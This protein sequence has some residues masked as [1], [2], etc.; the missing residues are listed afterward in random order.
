MADFVPLAEWLRDGREPRGS[1]PAASEEEREPPAQAPPAAEPFADFSGELGLLRVAACEGFEGAA[2][3][4][5]ERLARDVLGRELA[6]APCD[7]AAL[8][9]AARAE[10]EASEPVCFVVPPGAEAHLPPGLAYRTDPRLAPGDLFVEVRD[11]AFD[12]R[13]HVRAN[14][15][16]EGLGE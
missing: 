12:A 4:L 7:L 13:L 2:R 10:L 6:L 5:L 16:L 15:A 14:R 1:A 11:G 3:R 8:V 9:D